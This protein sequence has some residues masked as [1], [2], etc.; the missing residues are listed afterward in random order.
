MGKPKPTTLS[1]REAKLVKGVASGMGKREA[2]IEAGYGG[3]PKTVSVTVSQALQKPHVR[4]ALQQE[5]ERQGITLEKIVKPIKDGLEAEKVSIVGNGEEAMAE[6]TPDHN[7][8]LKSSQM[9]QKLI[10]VDIG[11]PNGNTYN[12]TQIINEK[13]D[14]YA[15]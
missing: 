1:P 10:G 11:E 3:Q 15:D 12:F 5:M 8:R 2:G 7:I 6:I 4:E 13:A 9:A 14:K